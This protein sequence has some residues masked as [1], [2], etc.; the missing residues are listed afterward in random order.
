MAEAPATPLTASEFI[1]AVVATQPRLA[2]FDCDG[3][4]WSGDA[5]EDFLYWEL[6]RGVL[7]AKVAEWVRP[8][9]ADYKAGKVDEET[10]C[11]E[12]V[13]IHAGLDEQ[14]LAAAGEKFWTTR[15]AA[16]VFPAMQEL[17]GRLMD[18]GCEVWAVSSTNEWV[19]KA[20]CCRFRISEERVLAA[21][22]HIIN[23]RATDQ[24]IRVPTDAGKARVIREA[25]GRQPD[26]VFG[27]SVHDQAMLEAAKQ[28]YAV[29]PNDD[30]R[31]VAVE[32]GWTVYDP[33]AH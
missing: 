18:D 10:M 22:V 5:G 9:Y 14:R 26:A 13:T 7:P 15:V 25:I 1:A 32:R 28:A 17:V 2:V 30:L 24:L 23:G 8:R 20:G 16:R 11:G 4:L 33:A 31:R 21:S 29:N 19:I 3:T 12:M 27:N 6:D